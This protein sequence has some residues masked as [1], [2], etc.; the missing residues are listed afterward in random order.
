MVV[1]SAGPEIVS[2][3]AS[4]GVA[5]SSMCAACVK[6]TVRPAVDERPG[7]PGPQVARARNSPHN[8]DMIAASELAQGV[9]A[10]LLSVAGLGVTFGS[11]QA[12]DG[13]NLTVRPGELVALAGEN[14]AGKTTLVRCIAGDITPTQ[15]EI[16][17]SGRRVD[18]EPGRCGP[19]GRRR[20]LAG[21]GA[22]REPRRRGERSARPGNAPDDLLRQPLP[23]GRGLAAGQSRHPDPEHRPPGQLP[24]GRP[25]AAGG[26]GPRD[27]QPAAAAGPRR[28]HRIPRGH[29]GGAGRGAHRRAAGKGHDDPAR[30]PRHRPDV[31]ARRPDPGAAPGPDRRRSGPAEH[32]PR[33][34]GGP[35]VRASRWTPPR[36]AS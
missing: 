24:V 1:M 20:G 18:A 19:P 13:V 26:R 17:L 12:L 14:G 21:P 27:G 6:R 4:S 34:R 3:G 32:P 10:P 29:G 8:E 15:G 35:A 5:I 25:A 22:V 7:S 11:V 31:P 36:A 28:A 30:V 23:R 2:T 9:A 16:F 33:R